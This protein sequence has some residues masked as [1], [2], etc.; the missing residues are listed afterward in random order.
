[1]L[2]M[3]T[4]Q[5]RRHSSAN[6]RGKPSPPTYRVRSVVGPSSS[7]SSTARS[8]LGVIEVTVTSRSSRASAVGSRRSTSSAKTSSAPATSARKTSWVAPSNDVDQVHSTRSAGPR[9]TSRAHHTQVFSMPLCGT[10]T[11]FGRPVVPEV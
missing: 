6:A 10:R 9:S 11:P 4:C 5:R 7:A 1:M 3:G 8:R 2:R